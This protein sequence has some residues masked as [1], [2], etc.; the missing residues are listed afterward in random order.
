MKFEPGKVRIFAIVDIFTQ[1]TLKP[2][3]KAIFRFLRKLPT[4]AT[5]DQPIG[6]AKFF[7]RLP[8][9]QTVYSYDLSAATDRLP[10]DIQI[11][12]LNQISPNLGF[13]WARL[14]T[15]R[16]Y[17]LKHKGRR[18]DVAVKY[19]VGQPMGAYSS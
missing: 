4:D 10:L 6:L 14:L 15:E 9:G 19:R 3:H 13:N 5:F 8:K 17:G 7:D 16:F 2:L 18:V 12:I 1:W 11:L